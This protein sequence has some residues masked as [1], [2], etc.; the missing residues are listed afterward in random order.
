V[1]VPLPPPPL[2]CGIFKVLPTNVDAPLVPV[3]VKVNE[4]CFAANLDVRF[5]LKVSLW[6]NRKVVSALTVPVVVIGFGLTVIPV[7]PDIDVKLPLP[8]PLPAPPP[9]GK[10]TV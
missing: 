2:Y 6:V 8:P 10:I 4:F 5:K 9:R 7:P 3:V 1:T